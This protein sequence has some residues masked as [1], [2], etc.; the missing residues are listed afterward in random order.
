[1]LCFAREA[2]GYRPAARW[3]PRA[4][5]PADTHD[6]P[7]LVGYFEGRD[8][9][10]RHKLSPPGDEHALAGARAA[11]ARERAQLVGELV[12]DGH[13]SADALADPAPE[14]LVR[15]VHGFLA[16]TP[17]PLVAVSLDDLAGETEPLNL[18]GVAVDVHRSWTRRMGATLE[19]LVRSA[20]VAHTL[21]GVQP[22]ARR[23]DGAG[24]PA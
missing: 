22:R 16:A 15:A 18:P 23:A 5:A 4:L 19:G 11:R 7:P 14:E 1:V 9:E 12:R 21:A 3:S 8:L 10:L 17:C 24:R 13:L 2:D 20:T 6:L